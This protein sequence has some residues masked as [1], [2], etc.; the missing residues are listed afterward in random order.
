MVAA[1]LA[2]AETAPFAHYET[3]Q[4]KAMSAA[5]TAFGPLGWVSD[6]AGY[7]YAGLHPGTGAPWPPMPDALP[8]TP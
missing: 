6:R 2:A 8:D 7:R 3:P 4:G 1:L 5:M